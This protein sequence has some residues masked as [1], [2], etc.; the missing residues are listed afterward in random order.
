[1]QNKFGA[2]RFAVALVAGLMAGSSLGA[3]APA[4]AQAKMSITIPS[5]P[6]ADAIAELARVANVQILFDHAKL[7]GVR[8]REVRGATSARE[9]L[10]IMFAGTRLEVGETETG[11]LIVR[12]QELSATGAGDES[13]IVVTGTNIRGAAPESSQ[14]VVI[15][16]AAVERSGYTSVGRLIQSLS[17]NY[18]GIDESLDRG[19][20]GATPSTRNFSGGQSVNL[21]GLGAGSTLTLINGHRVAPSGAQG[22]FVDISAIPLDAVESVEVLTGGASSIYGGDAVAGVVNFKLRRSYDGLQ[23]RG[24]YGLATE[25]DLSEY[26]AGL[27]AGHEWAGGGLLVSYDYYRRDA[28]NALDRS[29]SDSSGLDFDLL[30]RQNRHSVLVAGS[31]ELSSNVTLNGD[32][33][34]GS[35][36]TRL[37]RANTLTSPLRSG[38]TN[39]NQYGGTLGLEIALPAGWAA[40]VTGGYSEVGSLTSPDLRDAFDSRST[41]W[42]G[43]ARADGTLFDLPGGA[44]RT[45]VGVAYR[46]EGI[47]TE[48]VT[49]AVV[50]ADTS[51][52]V[53]ALFGELLIPL[54]GDGNSLPGIN[55]LELS[56]SGRLDD[57]SD[58]GSEFTYKVGAAWRPVPSLKFSATYST[59]FNPPDLGLVGEGLGAPSINVLQNDILNM[60]LVQNPEIADDRTFLLVSG[61][62]PGLEAETS[63]SLNLGMEYE[64]AIG[65]GKLVLSANYFDISFKNRLGVAE[66]PGG[67]FNVIN[68]ALSSPESLP[69]GLVEFS[70]SLSSVEALIASS[71]AAGRFSDTLGLFTTAADVGIIVNYMMTNL[72]STK[73]R[74]FDFGATY[75]APLLDGQFGASLSGTYLTKYDVRN[76]SATPALDVLDTIFNPIDLKVR[77]NLSWSKDGFTVSSAINYAGSYKDNRPAITE[78]LDAWTTVDLAVSYAFPDRDGRNFLDN[79]K[80]SFAVQNIFNENPPFVG[81]NF[82]VGIFGYDATNANP[83]GRFASVSLVKNW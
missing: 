25:G 13:E 81:D 45:A 5:Q 74:G 83:L 32:F 62:N 52:K 53:G 55:L 50:E 64:Q 77:G 80:V 34:Y 24:G 41:M 27:L 30:P 7:K 65:A 37:V 51:R 69:D 46:R 9:A 60:L 35:R 59:A 2:K 1:M 54:I 4:M 26:R 20:V 29:F 17:Q 42:F 57:Y 19:S 12:G 78:K 56:L 71:Q 68:V 33:L 82:Q 66:I 49:D 28:L 21:R 44:V 72:S 3:V 47:R 40:N 31:Q 38:T 58:F 75:T 67:V 11:A 73:V 16:R 61:T 63:T 43:E 15:D 36:R 48:N 6:A 18:N 76:S 70:P 79:M 8:T 23:T 10:S 39:T 22:G 14:L